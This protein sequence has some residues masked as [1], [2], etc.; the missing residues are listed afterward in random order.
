MYVSCFYDVVG[1]R[2]FMTD[3]SYSVPN[4]D[5]ENQALFS[6]ILTPYRSLGPSGFVILMSLV[7]IISFF[8]GLFFFLIG[9]WPV[10]GFLG[11]DVL[12]IYIA[13]KMNYRSGKLY[14]TVDLVDDYLK[15]TRVL[16]SGKAKTWRFN[17]YWVRLDVQQAPGCPAILSLASHGNVL[18]FGQF[19]TDDEK[20]DFAKALQ[21]A[22]RDYRGGTKI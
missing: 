6:A 9:A 5:N 12:L 7:G 3:D 21:K 11:L 10:V 2:L 8:A 22:L 14:E 20:Y 15:V 18:V 13:F 19:L 17:A 1:V 4:Q 16:P